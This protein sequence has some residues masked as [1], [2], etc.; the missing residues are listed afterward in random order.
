MTKSSLIKRK[1]IHAVKK[2]QK[3]GLHALVSCVN[4]SHLHVTF[5]PWRLLHYKICVLVIS[6]SICLW[7]LS[8]VILNFS[9]V[10]TYVPLSCI[11]LE[12]FLIYFHSCIKKLLLFC[13]IKYQKMNGLTT[14]I[15]TY[16]A[17]NSTTKCKTSRITLFSGIKWEIVKCMK[18]VMKASRQKANSVKNWTIALERQI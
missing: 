10:H 14:D 6:F 17:E 2:E 3:T 16:E 12:F 9:T 11:S 8:L 18:W 13:E 4:Y 5:I 1:A 7:A 15:I